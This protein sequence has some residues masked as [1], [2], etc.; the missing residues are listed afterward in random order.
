MRG[1]QKDPRQKRQE[2]A[3]SSRDRPNLPIARDDKDDDKDSNESEDSD[4]TVDYGDDHQDD[5]DDYDDLVVFDDSKNW[6]LL[7]D[8]HRLMANTGSFTVVRDNHD[9]PIDIYAVSTPQPVLKEVFQMER[10]IGKFPASTADI[11]EIMDFSDEDM[12][13][14]HLCFKAQKLTSGPS[15][16]KILSKKRKEAS[17]TD[18]RN[19]A[20]QFEQAKTDEYKSW[21]DHDVFDLVDIRKLSKYE[22]RNLVSGRWVLTV[23]RDKN[24]QFLKC[25]ARWVLRGFQD[26]QKDEQQKDSPAA[27]RPGFR[28]I[29]M[30]SRL[31]DFRVLLIMKS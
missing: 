7:T 9:K 1:K 17:A 19:Y 14:I 30:K 16:S 28:D 24:G 22:R 3:S 10:R 2:A 25:K 8:D 4:K 6:G 31:H 29:I 12:A 27:S 11:E 18:L 21:V 23:K 13:V 15:L 5:F 26:K 20:R